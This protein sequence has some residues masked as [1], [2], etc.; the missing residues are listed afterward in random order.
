VL[1]LGAKKGERRAGATTAMS[2]QKQRNAIDVPPSLGLSSNLTL[3]LAREWENMRTHTAVGRNSIL[4]SYV[5]AV[6]RA[7]DAAGCDGAALL[8]EAGFDLKDLDGPDS[9][10]PLV[11][12]GH[13]WRIAVAATGDPAFGIKVANHYKHTTFHALGYGTSAS[14]TLKEAF[15][16]V[17]RYCHVVSDAVDY[18][19]FRRGTE[20]HFII[21]PAFEISVQ[22]IDA[23]VSSYLRM[24]RSMIGSHYSPLSIELRRA[25]PA[26]TDDYERLWRAPLRFGAE[27]NRL[28]FDSDS[29]ERLL[30]TGN[31]ELA[32]QSDAISSRYLAR[33]ERFNIVARVREALTQ[34]LKD[35]EPSQEEVAEIL[36]VSARTLQRKL[37]DSGTTFKEI[38]DETRHALA[39]AYLSAP[40]S[41]SEITYLLG[42][43]CTS[44]FT[45]AF[46]RW[47]GL[48][49]SD[50]RARGASRYLHSPERVKSAYEESVSTSQSNS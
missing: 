5:K 13:L 49:P 12:T 16:R 4:G 33:I 42:F 40:H 48:S 36:N 38:L 35:R 43:S 8:A 28:I 31:P 20:Y 19:F 30:D 15:E 3:R 14:S 47:T 23:L 6:G 7:L 27:Q 26:I 10:C 44:S 41:V 18:Q 2:P 45:R 21:E 32:R 24:C 25:R 22:A 37:G 50:W 29:I 46:R 11:N 9:R 34:R 39:L 17:Q 1:T